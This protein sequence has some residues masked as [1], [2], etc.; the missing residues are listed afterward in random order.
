MEI[1]WTP[2]T[3]AYPP[4][5]EDVLFCCLIDDAFTRVDK[6]RYKGFKTFDD[7]LVMEADDEWSPCSHWMQ[8]PPPPE[9]IAAEPMQPVARLPCPFCGDDGPFAREIPAKDKYCFV[10]RCDQ[11]GVQTTPRNNRWIVWDDWNQRV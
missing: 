3:E 11:C 10:A 8:L 6:G 2:I 5:G 9:L 4:L 1:K 7:A